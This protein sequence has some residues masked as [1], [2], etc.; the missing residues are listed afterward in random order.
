[1]ELRA[2]AALAV[3]LLSGAA[4]RGEVRDEVVGGQRVTFMAAEH[5]AVVWVQ[6]GPTFCTGTLVA[7]DWVLTAA[8]CL[9][10]LMPED[11]VQVSFDTLS[12]RES[13]SLVRNVT[14]YAVH[15]RFNRRAARQGFDAALLRLDVP[16]LGIT[17]VW[18]GPTDLWVGQAATTTGYG[19]YSIQP[20]L[21]GELNEGSL[22]I[23]ALSSG[24]ILASPGPAMGCL[25]DSGAPL[26][27]TDPQAGLTQIGIASFGDPN[28]SAYGVFTRISSV[29][30]WMVALFNGLEP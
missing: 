7:Q 15:P 8:H 24:A 14:E 26:F 2:F 10:N 21:Y 9:K 23:R 11:S 27:V 28:C 1:M 4:I 5:R 12:I 29:R 3:L 30:E 17:P 22:D 6:I 19:I 16:I 13:P 18:T 25:G 20:L